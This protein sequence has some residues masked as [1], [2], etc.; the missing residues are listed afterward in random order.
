MLRRE[1]NVAASASHPNLVAVLTADLHGPAPHLLLPF[2]EGMTSRQLLAAARQPLPVPMSLWI[3]RQ[4]AEALAALHRAGWLHGQ[5]RP[6]HVIVSPQGHATLIDLSLCR[7]LESE[8]CAGGQS[9]PELVAYASPE[10]FL[11]RGRLTAASDAYQL[12]L[13]LHE[14]LAGRPPFESA[15]PTLLARMHRSQAPPNVGAVRP[16]APQEVAHLLRLMLAK[17]PLRRPSDDELVRW[18]TELEI[19]ALS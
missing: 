12:G 16:D 11:A 2:L 4:M 19:E 13:L 5:V 10:S 1:A 18:L 7:R 6:Q 17:E 3:A 15:D 14:L 8:E 9:P